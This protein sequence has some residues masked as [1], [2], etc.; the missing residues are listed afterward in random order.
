MD[1]VIV[2]FES[3][4]T[5]RRIRDIL[6]SSG[7]AS[8]L[9]CRS[10]DQIR[11]YVNKQ[12]ITVVICGYK[13]ADETAE[14]ILHDLPQVCSMLLLAS[15]DRLDMVRSDGLFSLPTPVSRS[16]LTASV[17]ML[18]QLGYRRERSAGSGRDQE[19]RELI[20]MAKQVLME[21]LSLTE[22]QAHRFLQKKSMDAGMKLSQTAKMVLEES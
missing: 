12:H 8:C 19:E 11:R 4:K 22:E 9:T 5:C 17:R 1:Q 20:R 13:L 2:A 6:E 10:G 21:R 3:E 16:E 14:D 18:L 15:Q 7:A